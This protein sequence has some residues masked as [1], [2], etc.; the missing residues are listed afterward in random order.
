MNKIKNKITIGTLL[1]AALPVFSQADVSVYG[2]VIYNMIKDD[3]SDDLYFGRHE[4]AES[5]FGLKASMDYGNVKF[6]A[7]IEVGLDEGVSNL[8]HTDS[9]SRTR[10]QEIWVDSAFGKIKMGTGE[11]I[12]WIVGDVDQSGTWLSDP[13]GQSQRF[14]AT[15]RGP[16]GESQTP[17]IQSQ[18]IFNERMVYES[19]KFLGGAKFYAQLG[20]A[21][22]YETAIKYLANGWR[23][24]VWGADYGDTDRD[25]D[26]QA[27]VDG[28]ATG[29]FLG[30]ERGYGVL[31]GY[32]HT[33]GVNFTATYGASELIDGGENEL[34][35]WKLGYTR[36]KHAVSVS[37]GN[38]MS[39]DDAGIEGA[40][41]TRTTLAYNFKPLG[42]IQ[43][44]AQ[45]TL[46]ET[47]DQEDFNSTALGGMIKF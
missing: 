5:N 18:S 28:N 33:S 3:T 37:M 47:D 19:P 25:D 23:I 16:S 45:T 34:A 35:N 41:H 29:G 11:S 2:R 38:Y 44:W 46:G 1:F 30:A 42:G 14:G 8:L 22:S 40:D 43:L 39:E 31:A 27:N 6:G 20:E 12:T 7:Q 24:N 32:K 36:G 9:N 15:R 26:I 17:L 4:F 10:I 21:G 13:L